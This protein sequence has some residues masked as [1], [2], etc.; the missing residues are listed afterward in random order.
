VWDFAGF[1][2]ARV[3]VRL[4][5]RLSFREWSQAVDRDGL[6]SARQ[7]LASVEAILNAPRVHPDPDPANRLPA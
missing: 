5:L 6:A 7:W 3:K 1:P 4:K 2:V